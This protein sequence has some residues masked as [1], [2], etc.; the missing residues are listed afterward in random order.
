M[1][2]KAIIIDDESAGRNFLNSL[3]NEYIE[4][5]EV[6]GTA[7]SALEGAKL[8]QSVKIDVIFLDVEMPNGSGFDFMDAIDH[9]KYKIIL[10]TAYK[11]FAI[12]AFKYNVFGYL[13]KPID[14]DDLEEISS[15]LLDAMNQIEEIKR[16]AFRT[17]ESIE[18]IDP[19]DIIRVETEGNNATIYCISERKLVVSKNMKQIEELLTSEQFIKTHKSHLVNK[20]YIK[21]YIKQDGGEFEMI[22]GSTAPLSRRNREEIL[23]KLQD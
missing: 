23:K 19:S 18:Y 6:V 20:S 1:K 8:L 15:R 22:D 4:S 17:A 10:T 5:I 13:L 2:L 12:K 21:R 11:D 3:I 7:T 16:I 9:K 14:I